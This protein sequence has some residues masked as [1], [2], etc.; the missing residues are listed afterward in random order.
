MTED[1]LPKLNRPFPCNE[2]TEKAVLGI[3]MELP[4]KERLETLRLIQPDWFYR[5]HH[6]TVL[7]AIY[8]LAID[9]EGVDLITLTNKLRKMGKLDE[10]GGAGTISEMVM[11]NHST[12]QL[13]HYLELL[14][15]A[16][17]Q[18]LII[19][20]AAQAIHDA[21]I[22]QIDKK[23][24]A[25]TPDDIVS[26]LSARL[27]EMGKERKCDGVT[28]T[29]AAIELMERLEKPDRGAVRSQFP[30]INTMFGGWCNS[31][32]NII[33]GQRGSGK[34]ALAWQEAVYISRQGGHVSYFNLEMTAREQVMRGMMQDGIR[35]QSMKT[36]NMN[37][38]ERE[39]FT[40]WLSEKIPLKIYDSLISLEDII[41]QMR[42]DKLRYNLSVGIIDLVQRVKVNI[43]GKTREEELALVGQALKDL[44]K[45]LDIPIIILSHLNDQLRAKYCANLENDADTMF[46]LGAGK[47]E[48]ESS[49]NRIFKPMKNRGGQAEGNCA[50]RFVENHVRFEELG[51]TQYDIKPVK[52]TQYGD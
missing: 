26:A 37:S 51:F 32:L 24:D 39:I 30:W 5:P 36:L 17:K 3:L 28:T 45:E 20:Y 31:T 21:Q 11:M 15:E 42:L 16:A 46:I 10:C 44:A 43:K 9:G 18:R 1:L 7:G 38:F 49:P 19:M 13:H 23:G 40:K 47:T 29:D 22:P 2:E 34:S 33:G 50:F 25:V 52:T 27:L 12:V 6:K 8:A 48:D 4:P 14:G 41:M 35:T